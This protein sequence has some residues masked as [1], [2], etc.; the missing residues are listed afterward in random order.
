MSNN[1]LRISLN[2]AEFPFL[3]RDAT[4]AVVIPG[5]DTNIRYGAYSGGSVDWG[6]PQMLFCENVMPITRGVISTRFVD[7]INAKDGAIDF[8]QAITLRDS[9]ENNTLFSP[10]AGKNYLLDQA[11]GLWNS[12]LPFT[13]V[14]KLFTRAYV[15]GR[16][17][18][19]YEKEKIFEFVG[20][21]IVDVTAS[22]VFPTGFTMAD[23][24]GIGG[25]SNYLLLFLEIE[26]LWSSPSD[27][28][29]FD[30]AT[31]NGSGYQIPQDVR[32]RI[33]CILPV[34]GGAIIY[35]VRNAVA[36]TFTNNAALPFVFRGISNSGGVASY[37]QVAYDADERYQYVWGSGGLQKVSLQIAE[38]TNP[39]VTDFLTSSLYE[40]FDYATKQ[41]VSFQL[42]S[43]LSVKL[44]YVS[45]RYLVISYGPN[46]GIFE[47]ALL[48]D[49]IL[50][51]WGKIKIDH[52]DAFTY[53][54]PNVVGDLTIA[55]LNTT[56][57]GFGDISIAELGVGILTTSP[58]KKSIAFLSNM[59]K[60]DLLA[61]DYAPRADTSVAIFGQ[62]QHNRERMTTLHAVELEGVDDSMV[63]PH[64]YDLISLNGKSISRVE[65]YN[66]YTTAAGYREYLGSGVAKGHQLALVGAFQLTGLLVRVAKH[67]NAK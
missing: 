14:N 37:E 40:T 21:T 59:G 6:I 26:V 65:E 41:V 60:I 32:G 49:T 66:C 62:I 23:V 25:A 48:F 34:S 20:G 12:V 13:P 30:R 67:G 46:S 57:A 45:Q 24:R 29:N 2:A 22:L 53:P 17:F 35:T 61:I 50:Q 8:D 63:M 33:S 18:F 9:L 64:L 31:N 11:T 51:R 38:G 16:T 10:S 54:Y 3:Y 56:I 36:I 42:G 55:E 52:V 47:Y 7:L 28:L 39:E 58:P 15:S 4:R 1:T 19:C 43:H 5:L 44:T 27:P